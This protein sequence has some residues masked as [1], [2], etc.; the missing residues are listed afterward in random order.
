[1]SGCEV[2][3]VVVAYVVVVFGIIE[4]VD[5]RRIRKR[6]EGIEGLLTSTTEKH[7]DNDDNAYDGKE[8]KEKSLE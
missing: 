1:M 4:W 3:I 7:L 8:K 5:F 2:G 6:L